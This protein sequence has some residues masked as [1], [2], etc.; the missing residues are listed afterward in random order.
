[1]TSRQRCGPTAVARVR[2]AS[3]ACDE[4]RPP[5]AFAPAGWRR[6]L[7][8]SIDDDQRNDAGPLSVLLRD[9]QVK[10]QEMPSLPAVAGPSSL[11]AVSRGAAAVRP[12]ISEFLGTRS[13]RPPE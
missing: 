3:A 12:P 7:S 8:H 13:T 5:V 4:H 10:R 2:L 11:L 1:M 6:Y 9:H